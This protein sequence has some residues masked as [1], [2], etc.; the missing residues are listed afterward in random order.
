MSQ[1]ADSATAGRDSL[2][3]DFAA[4]SRETPAVGAHPD[5]EMW[6]RL[7]CGE[8]TSA[9][10]QHLLDHALACDECAAIAKA[11]AHVRRDAPTFDAGAPVMRPAAAKRAYVW[12]ALAAG[13]VIAVAGAIALRPGVSSERNDQ[14]D[15]VVSTAPSPQPASQ[16]PAPRSWARGGDAPDVRLPAALA[17]T[18]RGVDA[19]RD[20]LLQEFGAAIAPYRQGRHQEAVDA[21]TPLSA[22]Y[23]DVPEIAFYLGISHLLAGDP[24]SAIPPLR[25]ARKSEVVSADAR[26]FEAVALERSGNTQQATAALKELCGS[27]GPY[28]TRACAAGAEK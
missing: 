26:W 15:R 20:A 24:V 18:V 25:E 7:S 5:E 16:V 14:A 11:L 8:V 28:Q 12:L 3:S 2:S 21:L 27:P 10:R 22:R 6:V 13:V 23:R 4:L 9:E 19:K 17:L 1:P